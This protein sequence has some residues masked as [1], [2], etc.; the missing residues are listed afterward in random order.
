LIGCGRK[1]LLDFGKHRED[2]WFGKSNEK[3]A[4]LRMMTFASQSTFI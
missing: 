1:F 4:Q 3:T 2:I